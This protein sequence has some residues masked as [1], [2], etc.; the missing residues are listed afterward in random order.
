MAGFFVLVFGW[1]WKVASA[2]EG[3][4]EDRGA[5]RYRAR[6][7]APLTDIARRTAKPGERETSASTARNL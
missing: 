6:L 1:G 3:S 7:T 2:D 4:F 5:F